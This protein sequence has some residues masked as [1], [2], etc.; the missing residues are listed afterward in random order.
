MEVKRGEIYFADLG[1]NNLGSEQSGTRPVLII[2]NNIGNRF[3]PTVIV[4]CITSKMYKNDIPTHV[5]LFKD[6]YQPTEAADGESYSTLT[7]DSL[8]LCEQ[9]KTI[10]KSRL[11]TRVAALNGYDLMR[12]NAALKLSLSV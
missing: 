7:S 10:D 4:A 1:E 2:Q 5:R 11:R 9:L 3:S 6:S 12:V 8:V